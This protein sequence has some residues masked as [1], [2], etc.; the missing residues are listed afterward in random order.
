MDGYRYDNGEGGISGDLQEYLLALP[1]NKDASYIHSP[2][3]VNVLGRIFRSKIQE[4]LDDGRQVVLVYPVPEIG[5]NVPQKIA[6]QAFFYGRQD[7][8]FPLSVSFES[9]MRRSKNIREQ[10]DLLPDHPKLLK[11][12][13]ENLLCNIAVYGRCIA[14]DKGN[15]LYFDDNHLNGDGAKILARYIADALKSKVA[16]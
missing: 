8:E 9:F 14:E 5:W 3:R 2:D 1:S 12:R 16:R 4:L 10:L 7:L 11:I 15:P 6:K 13:P